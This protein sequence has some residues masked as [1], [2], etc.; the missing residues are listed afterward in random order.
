MPFKISIIYMNVCNHSII[1]DKTP[2]QST[3]PLTCLAY[4]SNCLYCS[5]GL[6][7][8]TLELQLQIYRLSHSMIG[9]LG[10]IKSSFSLVYV[11]MLYL[12]SSKIEHIL[13]V[14]IPTPSRSISVQLICFGTCYYR[15]C[16]DHKY[17]AFFF[18]VFVFILQRSIC[19]CVCLMSVIYVRATSFCTDLTGGTV[20]TE[21]QLL[22][23][24]TSAWKDVTGMCHRHIPVSVKVNLGYAQFVSI[25]RLKAYK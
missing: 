22:V 20:V 8:A 21:P 1:Y 6:W 3:S 23:G 25:R 19:A 10:C 2:T 7:T 12:V 14:I 9:Q 13:H 11:V 17:S 4:T 18:H 16:C 24:Y 15:M 5:F